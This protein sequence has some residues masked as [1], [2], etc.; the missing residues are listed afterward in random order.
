VLACCRPQLLSCVAVLAY[1]PSSSTP[2]P[3][4]AHPRS[5]P[6]RGR[7]MQRTALAAVL[8]ADAGSA[9][10]APTAPGC[11]RRPLRTSHR[12]SSRTSAAPRARA[13]RSGPLTD[14]ARDGLASLPT[15]IVV[16]APASA[17]LAV[18]TGLA[19]WLRQRR[20]RSSAMQSAR[21][22]QAPL[23][24]LPWRL[25]RPR[26]SAALVLAPLASHTERLHLSPSLSAQAA[27]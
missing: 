7:A 2:P 9:P 8:L 20:T 1:R 21:T 13:G 24:G 14:H 5:S 25:R 17:S 23:A 6:W 26:Q 22:A 19:G 12:S 27:L 18:R 16:P 15:S 3:A 10:L 11:A 4:V